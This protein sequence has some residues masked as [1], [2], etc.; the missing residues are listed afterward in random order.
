M[1][2]IKLYVEGMN[3]GGCVS[4]IQEALAADTAISE[5]SVDL[6]S[7]TVSLATEKPINEVLSLLQDAG[8]ES[9]VVN[10]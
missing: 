7:K 3:C 2:N 4:S 6:D 10:Q 5:V 1:N 8:Y 9:E